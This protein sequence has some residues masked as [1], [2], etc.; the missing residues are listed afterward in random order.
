VHFI[1]PENKRYSTIFPIGDIKLRDLIITLTSDMGHKDYYLA[2]IKAA[3]LSKCAGVDVIDISHGIE[4]YN[5]SQAAYILGNV[6]FDFPEGTIHLVGVQPELT[7]NQSHVLVRSRGHYFVGADNGIF[8]LLLDTAPDL[9]YEINLNKTYKNLTF[10]FKDVF[11]DVAAHLVKGG[12]PDVIG[13]KHSGLKQIKSFAPII[14]ADQI[15][16]Q[17]IHIDS[18]GNVIS[19]ITEE[20]FKEVGKNRDFSISYNHSFNKIR[21]I[22]N[23]YSD[24]S[25]GNYLAL[26]GSSGHLEI[27]INMG[28]EGKGG[29]ASSLLGLHINDDIRIEYT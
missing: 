4:P 1:A 9:A 27:A 17:V 18:Y 15:R 14:D 19:N 3:L 28:V 7:T 5:I 21:K 24:V 29:S 6:C 8:S 26:F 23:V 16:G 12:I 22:R 25:E 13:R 20:M 11:V 2:A 10:P